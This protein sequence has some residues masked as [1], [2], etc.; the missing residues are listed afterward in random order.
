MGS[1]V[2][3]GASEGRTPNLHKLQVE[4]DNFADVSPQF[5][6]RHPEVVGSREHVDPEVFENLEG[7]GVHW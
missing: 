3:N 2:E 5:H 1:L 4:S 6:R 7:Q